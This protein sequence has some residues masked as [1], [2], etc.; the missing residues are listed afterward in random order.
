MSF[1]LKKECG[2]ELSSS[3]ID[4][5][6][7]KACAGNSSVRVPIVNTRVF[8]F[9]QG[10]GEQCS[11]V[12]DFSSVPSLKPLV[13]CRIVSVQLL[14]NQENDQV[15]AKI[16]LEPIIAAPPVS[17]SLNDDSDS[18]ARD[19]NVVSFAKILTPSDA[20]NGGGFSVPRFC[21]DSIFPRLNFNAN[22]PVQNISIRDVHGTKWEFRHI[23]RGT[24]RRHLLTTGWSK[25][26][27]QKKLCAGDSVL[28]IKHRSG[29]LFV[30]IRRARSTAGGGVG[31]WKME[32]D[33][34]GRRSCN[35][36]EVVFRNAKG[37]I[38]A[39]SAVE[40]AQLA[41]AGKPFEIIYY[42]NAGS[43]D[44][45]V[46]AEAV[47]DALKVYWTVGFRV[48]M[49]METEDSTRAT[50]FQGTVS[51]LVA[52]EV[53]IWRN[54]LWRSLQVTWDEPEVLQNVKRV[55]PWEVE[56][57]SA[58]PQMQ[59]PFTSC[60]KMRLSQDPD[61]LTDGEGPMFFPMMGPY[62]VIGNMDPSFFNYNNFPA[63]MQGARH[64]NISVP[65]FPNFGD[66]QLLYSDKLSGHRAPELLPISTDLSIGNNTS[67]SDNSSSSVQGSTNSFSKQP[68]GSL[69]CKPIK[70]TSS[71]FIQLFG[72]IIQTKQPI[73]GDVENGGCVGADSSKGCKE[74]EGGSTNLSEHAGTVERKDG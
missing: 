52:S 69:V 74:T 56:L 49:A 51:S 21:A 2:G 43:P 23:Y 33:D 13:V 71:S 50:W 31:R 53:G 17:V 40:A 70:R 59:T 58:T 46:R 16:R 63:G 11:S 48:K 7:W 68:F 26:V 55:N 73:E 6:I 36:E 34:L 37:K 64:N 42:P 5:Y 41:S 4:P 28:F 67:Q 24:P 9:P 54:S 61:L 29:E 25:F 20:N 12:P 38:P 47:E 35:F 18:D 72:Q 30:G 19:A 65:S 14:A 39:E 1:L 32:D 27:N 45:V 57:V 66:H 44:F 62:S 3:S 10:H 15:F 8:Y 22:P 60:K